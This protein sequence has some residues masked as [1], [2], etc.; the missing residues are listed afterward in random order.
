[1]SYFNELNKVFSLKSIKDQK[2]FL[3]L[4]SHSEINGFISTGIKETDEKNIVCCV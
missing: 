2:L 3:L 1:M 4:D